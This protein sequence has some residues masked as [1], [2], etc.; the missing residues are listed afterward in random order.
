MLYGKTA[1]GARTSSG[2]SAFRDPADDRAW[3]QAF[4]ND[5]EAA[6]DEDGQ[7]QVLTDYGQ[8]LTDPHRQ[9][10]LRENLV[11]RLHRKADLEKM[12]AGEYMDRLS[13]LDSAPFGS[14]GAGQRQ[15]GETKVANAALLLGLMGQ[16]GIA[17]APLR[18]PVPG[19]VPAPMGRMTPP[20]VF[21]PYPGFPA[22]KQVKPDPFVLP[23]PDRR[24]PSVLPGGGNGVKPVE[25]DNRTVL[26]DQSDEWERKTWLSIDATPDR[27]VRIYGTDNDKDRLKD[28]FDKTRTDE[29]RNAIADTINGHT[30]FMEPGTR[31]N[32]VNVN[33]SGWILQSES[34]F[35]KIRRDLGVPESEVKSILEGGERFIAPSGTTYTRLIHKNGEE[36]PKVEIIIRSKDDGTNYSDFEKPVLKIKYEQE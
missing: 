25:E 27:T 12:D 19:R 36:R 34:D 35:A 28:Y 5:F 24:E 2:H 6:D 20:P 1:A 17:G 10:A 16:A 11:G 26:P 4:L 22:D 14:R 9:D 23:I 18:M 32:I 8:E 30:V 13:A 31:K 7:R 33:K 21:G 3:A 29:E 15:P